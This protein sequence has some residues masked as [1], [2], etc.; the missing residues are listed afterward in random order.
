MT[1]IKLPFFS[2]GEVSPRMAGRVDT[3]AY[4][5]GLKTAKNAIVDVMGGVM[6][7][8]GTL[9]IGTTKYFGTDKYTRLIPFAFN[10]NDTHILEFGDGYMRVIREDFLQ[11]SLTPRTITGI[12][13]GAIALIFSYTGPVVTNGQEIRITDVQGMTELND[14]IY[15]VSDANSTGFAL[16]S[17]YSGN[18]I[19]GDTFTPYTGG[20][21]FDTVYE[22]VSPYTSDDLPQVKYAQSADVLFMTHT[23]HPPMELRRHGLADWEFVESAFNSAVPYPASIS[24]TPAVDGTSVDRYQVTAIS[25][26]T[27]AESL[28]GLVDETFNI[29]GITLTP[30]VTVTTVDPHTYQEF[31]EVFL[32]TIVGTTELNGRRF[33][34]ANVDS[35]TFDLKDIDGSAYTAYVSGGTSKATSFRL[36]TAHDPSDATVSWV[37][38]TGANRYAI[39]KSKDGIFGFIG[40]TSVTSFVDANIDP[41]TSSQ[42]PTEVSLFSIPGDYPGAVGFYQQ[43]KILGGS[44][45]EPDTWRASQPGDYNNYTTS[46]PTQDDD[47]I[48]N[49]LTSGQV[50]QIKH[51]IT[52]ESLGVFTS[53]QEWSVNSGG[54]VAF[55]PFTVKQTAGTNWGISEHRPYMIG[56]TIVF[57]QEDNRT[58]RSYTYDTV[59]NSFKSGSLSLISSH[60]FDTHKIKD[61]ALARTP[62]SAMVTTRSDGAAAIMVYNEEQNVIGWCPWDTQGNF[63]SVAVSRVCIEPETPQPDDGIYFTVRRKTNDGWVR[64]IERLHDRRFDD[65]RDAFFVDCGVTY[66]NPLEITNIELNSFDELVINCPG[67]GFSN[68]QPVDFSNILWLGVTDVN[69]NVVQPDQLNNNKY[70]AFNCTT[71]TFQIK[72]L[73]LAEDVITSFGFDAPYSPYISG[74]VARLNM[75]QVKNLYHLNGM[76]V[77]VL[78]DGYPLRGQTV[79]NGTVS[80]PG[81]ASRIH[82]GL[83]YRTDIETLNL[84]PQMGSNSMQGRPKRI[85]KLW[86][87]FDK[88]RELMIGYDKNNFN[89]IKRVPY[90]E[91]FPGLSPQIYTGDREITMPP[92]WSGDARVYLRQLDPL[93]FTLLGIYP[94]FSV[95]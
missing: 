33:T 78:A 79:T 12:G 50:N 60:I 1:E 70:M 90:Q 86:A 43:R 52:F 88:S 22:I 75:A 84:E 7:R 58:V 68:N 94:E 16:K 83:S 38:A 63:E 19:H 54:E 31:D 71:D 40:E 81:L 29:F 64:F 6:N 69:G 92:N 10:T 47:A 80:L 28:P 44:L 37:P 46:T 48:T 18:Y 67:H 21:V 66:D 56:G 32:D 93:P 20:G 72:T 5:S 13:V 9:L 30:A 76:F 59:Y 49:T 53:G 41:D 74:G 14:G 51:F 95:N 57:V 77:S 24:A 17:K 34:I 39:Y 4:Q 73:D 3:A 23:N 45:N 85:H 36:S 35:N 2:R 42:P 62:Y 11:L 25:A 89:P 65:V 8:P 55:S 87:R 27:K 26:A 82:I 15:I 61:W 91:G